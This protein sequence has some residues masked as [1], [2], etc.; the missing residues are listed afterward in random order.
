MNPGRKELLLK[1]GYEFRQSRVICGYHWQSDVDAW[2]IAAAARV[3]NL[4]DNQEFQ[5]QLAK[6]NA[7]STRLVQQW[8][9]K[10]N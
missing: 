1:H 10:T 2:R 8:L 7:E 4:H 3:S 9:L 6:A 5:K